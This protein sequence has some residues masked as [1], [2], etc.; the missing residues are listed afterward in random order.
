MTDQ[1]TVNS[2]DIRPSKRSL[3]GFREDYVKRRTT[4]AFHGSSER[5]NIGASSSIHHQHPSILTKPLGLFS[6]LTF[7][8]NTRSNNQVEKR[9][10]GPMPPRLLTFFP[11]LIPSR[12]FTH[13]F[14]PRRLFAR[15]PVQGDFKVLS[16]GFRSATRSRPAMISM[17][18]NPRSSLS[19]WFAN[20]R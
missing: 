8:G 2:L 19:Q 5:L 20:T 6:I 15:I 7:L 17:V 10:G 4:L 14:P 16:G 18:L 1:N 9:R 13:P 3:M 11:T 12:A